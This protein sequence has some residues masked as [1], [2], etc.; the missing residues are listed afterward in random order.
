[1][2]VKTGT[3]AS[4]LLVEDHPDNQELDRIPLERRSYRVTLSVNGQPGVEPYAGTDFDLILLDMQ[5]AVMD[6]IEITQ[7]I[8]QLE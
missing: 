6:G 1:M 3:W 8:R 4:L 2:P 5:M 7:N